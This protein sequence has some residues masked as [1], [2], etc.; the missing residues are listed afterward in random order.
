MSALLKDKNK[1]VD[2]SE[3]TFLVIDDIIGVRSSMRITISTFGGVKID[4]AANAADA[5]NKVEHRVYDIILCDYVLG[6]AKDGQQLL[7]ELKRRRM[8]K[9]STI[10]MMVTAERTYE[11]VVSAVE[12]APDDYLIKPFSGEVLR[13]RLERLI[14]KKEFL[15]PVYSLM[16]K[17]E[18][19]GAVQACDDRLKAAGPYL[20]DLMRIKGEMLIMLS[21]FSGAGQIYQHILAMR[22]IPWARMGLSKTLYFQENY[23]DAVEGFEQIV[24]EHPNY[25]SAYDWL[26]K[27]YTALGDDVAA[28]RVL[29]EAVAKSP[30]TLH[31]QK[32]LGEVAYQNEDLDTAQDAFESVLE[33]GK[34]SSFAE[35]ED[36]ANL[37][38]VFL[39]QGEYGQALTVMNNARKNFENSD[40]VM[41]HAAVMES[42]IFEK[43][44]DKEAAQKAYSEA[45]A[46]F[47]SSRNKPD[48]LTLDMVR[49]CYQHGD[50]AAAE[51]IAQN[52]VK[53][54][55]DNTAVLKRTE[56][57]FH[58]MGMHDRGKEL[59]H[60][61]SREVIALNNRAVK[62]A[63]AGDLKGSVELLM[64][65]ADQLSNNN[66]VVLNATHAILTYLGQFGWDDHLAETVKEYLGIV[67]KRDPEN[68]KFLILSGLYKDLGT[69]F[70]VKVA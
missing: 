10:F 12:L 46:L 23:Q 30:R 5:I 63:Q 3:K 13:V 7:E 27:S 19:R 24:N 55:H 2:F 21:D 69:K 31:R 4:M 22:E 44:G 43:T 62:L 15:A 45:Q 56:Q 54:N 51:E 17:Q 26:A 68:K 36:F 42:M 65:A 20:L 1:P 57:M 52:L 39:D 32:D 33:F 60:S 61:S 59:I 34:Y 47:E 28:Q 53:N 48:S 58:R 37:S 11:R 49:A 67:K 29:Q 38:R 50:V 16:E 41:L 66:V 40:A 8:I 18:L 6:D 70:G 64:Q 25:M 14:R 9:N 35:P